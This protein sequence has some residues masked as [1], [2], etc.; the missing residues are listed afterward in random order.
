METLLF[1]FLGGL[2]GI[3]VH[4]LIKLNKI[5]Q[6]Q[7]GNTN[8]GEYWNMERFAILISIC[9]VIVSL[10][11]QHEIKQLQTVGNYMVLSFFAIGYM[12]QSIVVSYMGKAEK[13]LE[14]DNNDKKD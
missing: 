4:N 9:V 7:K 5:N 2:F 14:S 11:A 8:L 1:Y 10:I 12:A 3:L 13:F 6:K